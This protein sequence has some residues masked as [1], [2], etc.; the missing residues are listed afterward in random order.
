MDS[1]LGI[2]VVDFNFPKYTSV[3][4]RGLHVIKVEK[5]SLLSA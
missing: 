2:I 5:Q 3:L 4:L 1:G